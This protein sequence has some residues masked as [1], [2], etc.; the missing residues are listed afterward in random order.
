MIAGFLKVAGGKGFLILAYCFM[1][2]HVHLLV[3]GSN[4]AADL[5]RFVRAAKQSTG[6]EFTRRTGHRLWQENYFDRTLRRE[7][8]VASV[9]RY[10]LINPIRAGIVE[11]L[12]DYPYWGSGVCTRE[13]LLESISR[14]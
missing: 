3:E 11:A 9:V 14:S 2:D 13:E 1:S 10:L 4:D 12:R 7:D 8:A 5:R 6:Y